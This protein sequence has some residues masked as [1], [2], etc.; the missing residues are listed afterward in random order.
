MGRM[1]VQVQPEQKVYETPISN[2]W[3]GVMAVTPAK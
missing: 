1:A 2:K 3:L